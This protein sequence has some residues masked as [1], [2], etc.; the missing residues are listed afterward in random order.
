MDKVIPNQT[1]PLHSLLL[2]GGGTG[3]DGC[4]AVLMEL[5]LWGGLLMLNGCCCWSGAVHTAAVV[6]DYG[7][8]KISRGC[9]AIRFHLNNGGGGGDG[10]R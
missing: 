6:R 1:Y 4:C 10:S 8:R 3:G 5:L 7:C 9:G 2:V